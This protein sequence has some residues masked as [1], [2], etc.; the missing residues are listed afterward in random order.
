MKKLSIL[1][2]LM[3]CITIDP[4]S[5]TTHTTALQVAVSCGLALYNLDFVCNNCYTYS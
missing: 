4:K 2:A 1:I 5:G 3:L